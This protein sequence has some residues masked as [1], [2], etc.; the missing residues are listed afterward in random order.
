MLSKLSL[1]F[2]VAAAGKCPFGY[3]TPSND[4]ASNP[5]PKVR[6]SA[7]YPSEIFTCPGLTTGFGI[8][9]TTSDFDMAKY[10]EIIAEVVT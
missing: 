5:H 4:S 8:P 2:A 1:S 3:D 10:K 9:T 6:S 7:A